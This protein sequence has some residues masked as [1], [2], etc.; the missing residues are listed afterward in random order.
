MQL[1]IDFTQAIPHQNNRESQ[2]QVEENLNHFAGQTL[3]V[4]NHLMLGGSLDGDSAKEIYGIK[5]LNARMYTIRRKEFRHSERVVPG[6]HGSKEWFMTE[7]D[8]YYNK[9]KLRGTNE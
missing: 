2:L 7:E 1:A 9:Q 3:D 6:S 8:I 5:D 4:F